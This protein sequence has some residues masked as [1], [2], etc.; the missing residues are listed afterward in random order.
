MVRVMRHQNPLYCAMISFL[1]QTGQTVGV[2]RGITWSMIRTKKS[3]GIARVP[4][5]LRRKGEGNN[6]YGFVIGRN[7]MTL[8][9]EMPETKDRRKEGESVFA[10]STRQAMRIIDL[11]AEKAHV[12]DESD[13]KPGKRSHRVY[14]KS[15]LT[16]WKDTVLKGQMN[17]EISR[18]MTGYKNPS[19][20]TYYDHELLR[21]YIRAEPLLRVL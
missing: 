20:P 17:H 15:F 13:R 6:T 4:Y 8:L 21:E 10:I 5:D 18:Y 12:Q 3:H 2:L 19:H 16:Y 1:I 9:E 11:V 7:T 14:P